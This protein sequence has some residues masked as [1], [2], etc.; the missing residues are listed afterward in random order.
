MLQRRFPAGIRWV[1]PESLHLTVKFI[2]EI[3]DERALRLADSWRR[4][5]IPPDPLVLELTSCGCFPDAGPERILWAGVQERHGSWLEL[6]RCV[7]MVLERNGI[8]VLP[9]EPVMHVTLGRIKAPG[10]L[11]ALRSEVSSISVA[12]GLLT[13]E[14]VGLFCSRTSPQ[15]SRYECLG[16]MCRRPK[17]TA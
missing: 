2:G 9:T 5:V 14:S 13:V 4:T 6:V 12:S 7:D 16:A 1:R 15:G 17:A 11:R 3:E 10:Q 8:T